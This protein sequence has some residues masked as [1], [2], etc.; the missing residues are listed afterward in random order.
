MLSARLPV[1]LAQLHDRHEILTR[2]ITSFST[3]PCSSDGNLIAI[4]H[5]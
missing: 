3:L 1:N 2:N 5:Q 4:A